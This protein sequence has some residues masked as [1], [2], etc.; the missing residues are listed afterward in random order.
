MRRRK[1][2]VTGP[3]SSRWHYSHE[4]LCVSMWTQPWRTEIKSG[5]DGNRDSKGSQT[6]LIVWDVR[7]GMM[8]V[9]IVCQR[10]NEKR[11]KNAALTFLTLLRCFLRGLRSQGQRNLSKLGG[12][13][14]L[15][16][17]GHIH[18]HV[19]DVHTHRDCCR[20][21]LREWMWRRKK[22]EKESSLEGESREGSFTCT[23]FF[24][25]QGLEAVRG[26][27]QFRGRNWDR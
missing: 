19:L 11:G 13:P 18:T 7:F 14:A 21:E 26:G 17:H 23:V 25:L 4:S 9:F 15:S 5:G 24:F 20:V 2:R 12:H 1:A 8:C 3:F 16:P 6:L 10:D 22:K 27:Q